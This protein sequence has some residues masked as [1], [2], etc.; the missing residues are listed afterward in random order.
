MS[1]T[2]IDGLNS[3]TRLLLLPLLL[4]L[5]LVLLLLL[6]SVP[7]EPGVVLG[8]LVGNE[9]DETA[10]T[11]VLDFRLPRGIT[12]SLA[13]AALAVSGLLMQSYFRNP[14]AGPGVL[15][16]TSGAGLAVAAA[17]LV[18]AAG[19]GYR[20]SEAALS[21][22]ATSG[23]AIVGASLVLGLILLVSRFISSPTTLLVLGVLFGYASS[24]LV[25]LLM[26]G[27]SAESLQRYIRWSYGSFDV[28]LGT[29]TGA[30]AVLL[31]ASFLLLQLLG[32]QLDALLL[33]PRYARS[34]GVAVSRL[35]PVL[36]LVAGALTGLT[37]S[38]C[39]PVAF[40]GVAV[41]HLARLYLGSSQHRLVLPATLLLGAILA[42]SADIISH[43]P[44]VPGV[45]PINAVTAL[46]GVPVVIG[47]LMR[48]AGGRREIAL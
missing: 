46:I 25:T 27:S 24:A 41:P 23:A 8:A 22:L 16:V 5:L 42:V 4:L 47:V 29:V 39:G 1:S 35:T 40:L 33:G 38:L 12:A 44:G 31:L 18:G 21:G 43:L 19:F 11:I 32:P 14:L 28:P 37:T 9:V 2:T 17:V 3:L 13:G 20:G 7:L 45:L 36:L 6:G 34:S 26:A 10:R 30:L 48:P 15:G